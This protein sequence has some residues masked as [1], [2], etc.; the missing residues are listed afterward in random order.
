MDPSQLLYYS[1]CES[2][3]IYLKGFRYTVDTSETNIN[4]ILRSKWSLSC[5]I[6]TKLS[7][8]KLKNNK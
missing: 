1:L 6:I 7:N 3:F 2:W 4:V 5:A 8:R